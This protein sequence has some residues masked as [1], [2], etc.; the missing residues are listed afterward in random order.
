MAT[1][2]ER[3]SQEF[4]ETVITLFH[5]AFIEVTIN[6]KQQCTENTALFATPTFPFWWI[7]LKNIIIFT[8][9]AWK[10]LPSRSCI[11][12]FLHRNLWMKHGFQTVLRVVFRFVFPMTT[13]EEGHG[14]SKWLLWAK[15]F[16]GSEVSTK[17]HRGNLV[18]YFGCSFT[19]SR[20]RK[21]SFDVRCSHCSFG[22]SIL[23]E[24]SV[25]A[26][27]WWWTHMELWT[28]ILDRQFQWMGV[29]VRIWRRGWSARIL[30]FT[31]TG[32]KK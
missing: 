19:L 14:V 28:L 31:F 30:F 16:H 9:P 11:A 10:E 17:L 15:L 20:I 27:Q 7:H 24:V 18:V 25:F 21:L 5:L 4:A 6:C 13:V 3:L 22:V 29:S 23:C 8:S 32:N 12:P 1:N 2:M 26:I